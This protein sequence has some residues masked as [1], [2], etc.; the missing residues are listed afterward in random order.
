M[1][2]TPVK[3]PG[4]LIVVSVFTSVAVTLGFAC[5][6]KARRK[7]PQLR[8]ALVEC[9]AW[10]W[11][12][13]K[14]AGANLRQLRRRTSGKRFRV[15]FRVL[16]RGILAIMQGRRLGTRNGK[17]VWSVRGPK[18][19]GAALVAAGCTVT[20]WPD[21]AALPAAVRAWLAPRSTCYGAALKNGKPVRGWRCDDTGVTVTRLDAYG[22]RVVYR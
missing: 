17:A 15:V 22:P 5:T 20:A 13:E 16:A 2:V 1:I 8:S 21:V 19:L 14:P 3:T 7:R 10:P 11:A 6:A 12:G 4:L 9:T 18:A